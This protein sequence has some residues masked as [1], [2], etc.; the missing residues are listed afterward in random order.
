M[1]E[2]MRGLDR[3]GLEEDVTRG[4]LNLVAL[5]KNEDILDM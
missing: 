3:V 5:A 4:M 2:C 1:V